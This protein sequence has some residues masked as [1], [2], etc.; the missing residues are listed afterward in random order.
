MY[1]MGFKANKGDRWTF[2]KP[3]DSGKVYGNIAKFV[4]PCLVSF[5]GGGVGSK[6]W[7]V[8]NYPDYQRFLIDYVYYRYGLSQ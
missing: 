4:Y 7:G 8:G 6:G 5:Q 2:S 1:A 3:F